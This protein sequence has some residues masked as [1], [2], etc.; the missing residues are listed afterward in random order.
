MTNELLA[1]YIQQGNNGELIPLLWENVRKLLYMM[2]DKFY[3][4]H[5][6]SCDSSGVE[7]WD[8]KQASYTAFLEAVKAYEPDSGNKFTAYLKYPFKNSVR[9][10]LGIRTTRQEPLNN[11][12]SLDKE[13]ES[14][15]GN[16]CSMPEII[17]DNTSLDF[18]EAADRNSEAETIRQIVD[19]LPEPFRSVIKARYFEGLTLQAIAENLSVSPSRVRQL[20]A[21]AFRQLR[22]NKQLRQIR[23]EQQRHYNWLRLA[24]FQYSPEYYDIVQ[25]AEERQLSY[26]QKQAVLYSAMQEWEQANK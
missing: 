24:R 12:S 25:R 22:Q 19:T 3:S 2:S 17:A 11:C 14:S 16:T 20:K 21:K 15:D 23:T 6:A 4:L 5:K 13:I 7:A 18:V 26:G 8:I 9:E 10:L 1:E